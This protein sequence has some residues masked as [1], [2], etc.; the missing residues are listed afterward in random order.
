MQAWAGGQPGQLLLMQLKLPAFAIHTRKARRPQP[1]AFAFPYLSR[2]PTSLS[3]APERK[4]ERK[5]GDEHGDAQA[6]TV[7]VWRA[8]GAG[9]A[10]FFFA[11]FFLGLRRGQLPPPHP[12]VRS[13][14]VV[15][16]QR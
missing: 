10:R 16:S 9:H 13:D 8:R 12:P 15:M 6:R 14:P 3:R 7:V 5:E 11:S 1:R 4:K 2:I